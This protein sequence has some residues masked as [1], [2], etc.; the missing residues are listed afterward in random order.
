MVDLCRDEMDWIFA[1]L[2]LGDKGLE[3]AWVEQLR[4]ANQVL[5][6]EQEPLLIIEPLPL[7]DLLRL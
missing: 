5:A 2:H 3:L 4:A 1:S 7:H 6:I